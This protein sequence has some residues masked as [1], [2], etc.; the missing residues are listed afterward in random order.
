MD[1]RRLAADPG[2]AGA[3]AARLL[4]VG[5]ESVIFPGT[6]GE[7]E[8]RPATIN[9]AIWLFRRDQA[10]FRYRSGMP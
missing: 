10:T 8:S 9:P 3:E 5:E 6:L 2:P 4:S 7:A 1:D